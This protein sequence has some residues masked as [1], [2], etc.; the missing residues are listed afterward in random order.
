MTHPRD[1]WVDV[2]G[3]GDPTPRRALVVD[4]YELEINEANEHAASATRDFENRLRLSAAL[5]AGNLHYLREKY[6][7]GFITY[8]ELCEGVDSVLSGG[9][10]NVPKVTFAINRETP[11]IPTNPI[12]Q[13][14]SPD[15]VTFYRGEPP[16]SSDSSS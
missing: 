10:V 8:E 2:T 16:V 1:E 12:F 14:W 6:A 15:G 7:L 9:P 13:G 4:G 11:A 3:F 5:M